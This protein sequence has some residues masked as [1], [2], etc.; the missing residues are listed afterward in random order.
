MNGMRKI[1][2]T[3]A[4]LFGVAGLGTLQAADRLPFEVVEARHATVEREQM[5]DAVIE[6]VHRATVSAQT[7]GRVVEVNF[8][9]DDYVAKG[10]VIVRFR[11]KEQRAALAAAEARFDEANAAFARIQD[12]FR[13][14][15][16]SRSE[17]ERAEA[18]LKATGAAREQAKE[19]MEHT[20]VRAP[21]SGIVVE[22]HVE[23][24]ESASPGQPLVTGL[25]LEKLRATANI[26]QRYVDEV[27]ARGRARILLP[28]TDGSGEMHSVAAGEVTVSPYA[29]S[30]THTFRVRVGLP[31][32]PHGIYPGMFAKVA[33]VVGDERRLL[34]PSRAVVH[35][36][37]VTAV[38]VVHED[39]SVGFRQLRVG[40]AG[41]GTTEVLA[42]LDAGERVALDPIRAGVYLKESRRGDS[43]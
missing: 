27:R 11:D 31:D 12:L 16:V 1:A 41:Q 28:A 40:R 32:G 37:E 17:F 4:L 30:G 21:Y 29:H 19:Q 15:L 39:G 25:S 43:R 38:Y 24:G 9:V 13:R 33:F 18:S 8:D 10:D 7:S 3:L 36:S 23:P 26:P 2:L 22:R 20:V 35:R 5:F 42:G 34:V 6:A 14:D